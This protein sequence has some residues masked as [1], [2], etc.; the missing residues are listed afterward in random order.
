[1]R[2]AKRIV[3]LTGSGISAESGVATFRDK[4]GVWAK[5]DYREVATPQGFA[6]NPALVHDFY[7]QRRRALPGVQ[8][9]AAHLALAELERGLEER[10]G[11]LTLITQNVDD[12]H[13]RGGHV[14]PNRMH[15]LRAGGEHASPCG[16][17]RRNAALHG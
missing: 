15:G 9:N 16:V 12:L 2:D 13:E 8:P 17:V 3:I 4:D 7:N 5:Y 11:R 6:A 10:G 14:N 1:M